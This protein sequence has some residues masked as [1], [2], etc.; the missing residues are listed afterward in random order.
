MEK[1][2][3]EKV[4]FLQ[5]FNMKGQENYKIKMYSFKKGIFQCI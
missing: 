5:Y 2:S 1:P 4:K 3:A